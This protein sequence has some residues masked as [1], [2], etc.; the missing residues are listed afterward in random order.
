MCT[1]VL[2]IEARA[3][4]TH[5]H[6]KDTAYVFHSSFIVSGSQ[7]ERL[8]FTQVKKEIQDNQR[9]GLFAHNREQVG[10]AEC[11]FSHMLS[12]NRLFLVWFSV[13]IRI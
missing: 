1:S 6:C 9:Q 4:S 13:L 7:L 5:N 2:K 10:T 3:V 11:P 12:L 8:G